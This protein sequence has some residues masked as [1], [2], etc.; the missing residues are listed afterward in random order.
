MPGFADLPGGLPRGSRPPRLALQPQELQ[1]QP[2]RHRHRLRQSH[3]D[4]LAEADR[5][6]RLGP[7]EHLLVAVVAEVFAP[8]R[9]H[10]DQP[11]RPRLVEPHEHAERLH[12]GDAARELGTDM[13]GEEGGEVSVVGVPLRDH[14]APLGFRD[15]LGRLV[16]MLDVP[17]TQA[18]VTPAMRRHQR[19]MHDQVRIAPDRRG[20]MRVGSQGEPE[21]PE[22]LRAVIGL[23]H[24]AQR[25]HRDQLG[26]LGLRR[27]VQQSVERRRPQH[28]P[29]RQR[30]AGGLGRLAQ[31][32]D[33]VRARLLM[34]AV[35]ERRPQAFQLLRGGNVGEDHA[36]LDQ[37]VRVEPV[38]ERD[39][40]DLAR[41]GQHDPALRQ[42]EVERLALLSRAFQR[43]VRG[44]ERSQDAL[45]QR[46]GAV[47]RGSVDGGLHLLVMQRGGRAHQA[48]DEAVAALGTVG[49]EHHADGDAGAV[50]P[51]VQRTEVAGQG[52]RQ[53]RHD[54]VGKVGRVAPFPRLAVE[55]GAGGDVGRDVG[56]GDPEDVASGIGRVVVRGG[57]A[58]VVMV[59]R[60]GR[61]YRYQRDMTKILA[62]FERR[63]LGGFGLCDGFGR[64]LVAQPVLVDGD[65]GDGPGGAGIAQ[66][67]DD[68]GAGKTE[69]AFRT[70]L[71]RF[72]E[73]AVARASGIARADLPFLVGA[74]V[75]RKDAAAFGGG[76]EDADDAART[77]R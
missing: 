27:V 9:T 37:P 18:I 57:V 76:A 23:R 41:I 68:A 47:G 19:A 74:L 63:G 62:T 51:L 42:V 58:G 64:K 10:R 11:V 40:R 73:F 6:P 50:Q 14:R 3:G 54:A 46:L 4:A 2:A 25:G 35:E 12:A 36:F 34:D 32:F 16:E 26:Q 45:E 33:L 44:V 21:M 56:D 69:S 8:E 53:H 60:I 22:V 7:G 17:C 13:V 75:D 30:E 48:A 61:V 24:R 72:D 29:L 55:R 15:L 52:V 5:H 71:F 66:A 67:G 65:E 59:A 38:L 43:I 28:L 77:G 1:H 49:I 70:S 31:R 39:G 20:E